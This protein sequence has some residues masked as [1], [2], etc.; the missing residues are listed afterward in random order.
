MARHLR[1]ASCPVAE[2]LCERLLCLRMGPYDEIT[3]QRYAEAVTR[4]FAP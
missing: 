4:A 2:S 1:Q 3:R